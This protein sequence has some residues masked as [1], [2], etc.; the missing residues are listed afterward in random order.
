MHIPVDRA[1]RQERHPEPRA[2]H[3]HHRR[4]ARALDLDEAVAAGEVAHREGLVPQAVAFLQQDE[5]L[6]G[7]VRHPAG[8][9]GGQPVVLGDRQQE[10]LVVERL[11]LDAGPEHGQREQQQV[12]VPGPELREERLGTVLA[13]VELDA[14]V[15]RFDERDGPRQHVGGDGG[16]DAE[17]Q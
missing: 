13:E 12:E 14:R 15:G 3:L 1:R 2:D 10:G 11:L 5:A 7:E 9:R 4:E 16:D 17:A 6:A 8:G